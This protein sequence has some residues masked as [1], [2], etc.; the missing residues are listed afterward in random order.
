M[1]AAQQEARLAQLLVV[2]AAMAPT[3]MTYSAAEV[4][5]EAAPMRLQVLAEQPATVAM[6]A[7]VAAV[8]EEAAAAMANQERQPQAPEVTEAELSLSLLECQASA[9]YAAACCASRLPSGYRCA[10]ACRALPCPPNA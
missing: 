9:A 8:E 3:A 4:A 7:T 5:V 1:T 6:A 10:C 2:T